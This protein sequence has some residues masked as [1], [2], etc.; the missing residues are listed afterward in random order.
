MGSSK[1]VSD[2]CPHFIQE[3]ITLRHHRILSVDVGRLYKTQ[4]DPGSDFSFL[5]FQTTPSQTTQPAR[6]ISVPKN[7]ST[8]SHDIQLPNVPY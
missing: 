6:T 4:A 7:A 8:Q 2:H 1:T 3:L 5:G